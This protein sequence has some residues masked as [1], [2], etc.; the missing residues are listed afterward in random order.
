MGGNASDGRDDMPKDAR[1]EYRETI[2]IAMSFD[3]NYLFPTCVTVCSVME[4]ADP[5]KRYAFCFMTD[6]SIAGKDQGMFSAMAEKYPNFSWKYVPMGAK[7]LPEAEPKVSHV[8][9][10]T[11]YRLLIPDAIPEYDRCIYL[12]SDIIVYEDIAHLLDSC[13]AAADPPFDEC[14]LAGV[15]DMIMQAPDVGWTKSHLDYIGIEDAREYV[16]GG[17]LVFN[18]KLLRE[19]RMLPRFL[20][21]ARREY[22]FADQD[23]V[24]I[25]CRGKILYLP[26]KYNL[27]SPYIGNPDVVDWAAGN[28]EERRTMM[29]GSGAVCHFAGEDK[30]WNRIETVWEHDWYD[31]AQKLPR[32]EFANEQLARCEQNVLDRARRENLFPDVLNAN[33]L[34]LYG[35]SPAAQRLCRLLQAEGAKNIRCFCDR[36]PEKAGTSYRGIDCCSPSIIA[37]LPEDVMIV[38]CPQR[39]WRSI[40][41]DL[42]DQGVGTDRIV[43]FRTRDMRILSVD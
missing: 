30:P 43:R 4:H 36:A 28:E 39:P 31:A 29:Q 41:Q 32:T 27:L 6:E 12:D 35:F 11:Y 2:P 1:M 18:L 40:L 23:V 21:L 16:N 10:P 14:Y 33:G 17:I 19:D 9:A 34:V 22:Y 26:A 25:A 5:G 15:P 3:M 7:L 37:Q 42:K 38:I 13:D 8:T 20:E 24:N